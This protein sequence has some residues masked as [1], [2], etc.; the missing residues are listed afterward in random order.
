LCQQLG[1]ITLDDG[2]SITT[3]LAHP[4]LT[5]TGLRMVIPMRVSLVGYL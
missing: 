4:T 2:V 5:I 3:P 1:A